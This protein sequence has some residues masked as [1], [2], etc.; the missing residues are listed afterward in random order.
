VSNLRGPFV[1][2]VKSRHRVGS[3]AE[4]TTVKH[5]L[6]QTEHHASP[7]PD[8]VCPETGIVP[9]PAGRRPLRARSVVAAP[10]AAGA[11]Y[12]AA[13]GAGV[14]FDL[15]DPGKTQ[16]GEPSICRLIRRAA[17]KNEGTSAS[18]RNSSRDAMTV[19]GPVAGVAGLGGPLA[20]RRIPPE[21]WTV[22]P[23]LDVLTQAQRRALRDTTGVPTLEDDQARVLLG[24]LAVG[25]KWQGGAY[26]DLRA[27]PGWAAAEAALKQAGL[28]Y[29]IS[30]P[31]EVHVSDD[32]RFS[33]RYSDD[34][35]ITRELRPRGQAATHPVRAAGPGPN[36]GE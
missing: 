33:L 17:A 13:S 25:Q 27:R 3:R 12:L 5:Q 26:A 19:T 30:G 35:H 16:P 23:R 2:R 1:A 7:Q 31:D 10:V 34:D 9:D 20:L 15:T 32:V 36:T 24:A 4:E 29:S 22:T 14:P 6:L 8:T 11:I 28:I 18:R 21:T